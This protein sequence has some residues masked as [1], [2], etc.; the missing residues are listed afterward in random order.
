MLNMLNLYMLCFSCLF[1][2]TKKTRGL[3]EVDQHLLGDLTLAERHLI[4]TQEI[5]DV[6]NKV[7][8]LRLL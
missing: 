3:D 5:L 1:Y 2:K 4:D 6:R 7:C 8:K